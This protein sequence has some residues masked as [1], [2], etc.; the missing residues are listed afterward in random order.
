MKDELI[1]SADALFVNESKA[2][3]ASMKYLFWIFIPLCCAFSVL[4]FNHDFFKYMF[5]TPFLYIILYYKTVYSE[6]DKNGPQKLLI[7]ASQIKCTHLEYTYLIPVGGVSRIEDRS[8]Y[9]DPEGGSSGYWHHEFAIKLKRDCR[10]SRISLEEKV[11][12]AGGDV[13]EVVVD[14]LSLSHDDYKKMLEYLRER[15][16]SSQA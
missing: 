9:R 2:F 11:L 1:I 13:S 5:Y 4:M 16:K 10:I 6:I 12:L 14:N 3:R 7:S 8:K 15:L